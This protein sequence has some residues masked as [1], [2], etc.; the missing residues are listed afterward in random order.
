V[1]YAEFFA[2]NINTD[3]RRVADT[4]LDRSL[5]LRQV[6]TKVSEYRIPQFS[7]GHFA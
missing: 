1:P 4:I 2:A 7:C 5:A 6:M 3:T